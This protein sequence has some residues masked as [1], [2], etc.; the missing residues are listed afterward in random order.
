MYRRLSRPA[1]LRTFAFASISAVVAVVPAVAV[2]AP[3]AAAGVPM[4]PTWTPPAAVNRTPT[5]VTADQ[6]KAKPDTGP[7]VRAATCATGPNNG[8]QPWFPMDRF[9]ISDREELLVNRANGNVVVTDRALTVKG[10][11]LDLSVNAVYNGRTSGGGALGA[12]WQIS[13]GPDVKLDVRV[14]LVILQDP[15]GYCAEY[16]QNPDGSYATPAGS[17]TTLT[18]LPDGKYAASIDSSGETWLF[19]GTGRLISQSDRNGHAITYRYNAGDGGLASIVDTQGRVTT[20]AYNGRLAAITD[21][22]GLTAAGYG[23][24][25]NRLTSSTNRDGGTTGYGYDADG[26]L[27]SL[28]T[29]AGGVY[30]FAYDDSDRITRVTEPTSDGAGKTTGY[31][32]TDTTTTVTDPN[33]NKTVYTIDTGQERQTKATDAL[34]HSRAQGWSAHGDVNTVSDGLNNSTTYDYDAL[35][36]LKGGKLPTGAS[37]SIGYTDT[38]HPHLP[39]QSSDFSGKKVS[40]SYDQAGNLTKVRSD[41]LNADVATYTYNATGLLATAANGAQPATAYGYDNAGN[42]TS[43]TPPAP[44]KPTAYTYDSLSRVTS[45]T[46]GNGV[47]LVYGYDKLDHVV[48]VSQQDG[49][50]LAAY[51]FDK[52]GNRTSAQ[53]AP[54]KFASTYDRTQLSKVVRTAG[55]TSQTSTYRY[56]RAGNLTGIDD[57][58]GTVAYGYDAADRLTSLKD[59]SGATTTYGYDAADRRTSATLPGGTVQTLGYDNSGRQTSSAVKNA[60]GAT[61]VSTG[62][63]YTLANGTDTGRINQRTDG[64]AVTDYGYDGFGRLTQAGPRTFSYD[65]AGNITAG[66][67]RTFAHNTA[68]QMTKIDNITVGYDGAGNLTS[69]D[70]GG[71]A[72]YSATNQLTSITSGGSTAYQA[73]YDTLD[74]TQPAAVTETTATGSTTHIFT[75]NALGVSRVADNGKAASYAHDPDGAVTGMTDAAGKHHNA[76]TDYQGSVIAFVDDTGAV[77][78]SYGYTAY[79]VNT[80]ITGPAGDTNR[81]RWLGAYQLPDSG[82][83]FTGY[84]TYVPAYARFTQPDPTRRETN[85]YAYAAGDPVNHSDP[86][87]ADYLSCVGKTAVAGTITGAGT[88]AVTG[89]FIGGVGAVP[90]GIVGGGAGGFFGTIAGVVT[91]GWD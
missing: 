67:G 26:R 28:K 11:G 13:G 10:T 2:A 90:G 46:D 50:V 4:P 78:A 3:A 59:Q 45:V 73:S 5:G 30:T 68:G 54:A 79:G 60:A 56:D 9:A 1:A 84:R 83:Y 58:A 65:L 48:A 87:G 51:G 55:G 44:L 16:N 15:T 53:T 47:T 38:A 34:G 14:G 49:P 86:T 81:M 66:D 25:S 43:V 18:K 82:S 80:S 20:A 89:S 61:L 91:C 22:A 29:P 71:N 31:A 7:S 27:T 8:I 19:T 33:G 36:N 62:Y 72:H 74:Q 37:A 24:T 21:P 77:T 70:P 64:T 85:P 40:R 63:R 41:G 17:H 32:Y 75:R 12:H 35:N 76:I 6:V 57:P 39:T 88:G 69:T 52:I 23:Y 42:L